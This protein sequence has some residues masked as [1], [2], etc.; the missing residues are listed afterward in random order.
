M[1]IESQATFYNRNICDY[2]IKMNANIKITDSMLEGFKEY[3]DLLHTI[4]AD[5]HSYEIS[6]VLSVKTKIGIMSDDLENYH[7]LTYT[8]D[9]LY[10]LATEGKLC[11]P[12]EQTCLKVEK[13]LFKAAFKKSV[14][15]PFSMFEK[16]GFSIE[17][18]KENKEVSDYKRC[19]HFQIYY[20]KGAYLLETLK[21]LA[22]NLANQE[23][24]KE[25]PKNVAFMLADYYFILKGKLD[26]QLLQES[27]LN[28][29]G[30][31][32]E[33]WKKL[34]QVLQ[35]EYKLSA[36]ISINPFVFPNKTVTFKQNKR[37]ICK[38]GLSTDTLNVRL[39]LSYEMAK[40]LIAR[41]NSL[42][43]SIDDN[44]NYFGCVCCGKCDNQSN[45]ERFQGVP[46][47][48]LSYSNFVTEDSRCLRFVIT[49]EE[50]LQLIMEI[51]KK[52]MK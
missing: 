41:R 29:L 46:L 12:G 3:N 36:D 30:P 6:T 18:Y 39:P 34:V 33:L 11:T 17:Y 52:S 28:T 7:N 20:K 14:V 9:C 10:A 19:S 48:N 31:M 44:I 2:D 40:D 38:F 27:I 26:T 45:I 24:Q 5:W 13:T 15:L 21:F 4:Y 49:K 22:D 43:K 37:T 47:C 1:S 42:P 51:I 50:E 16:Y 8:L 23:K 32:C 25:M 35:D